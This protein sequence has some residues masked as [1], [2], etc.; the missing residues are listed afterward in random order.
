MKVRE[1]FRTGLTKGDFGVEIEVEGKKL[2]KY[3]DGWRSEKDGSLRGESMEYVLDQPQSSKGLNAALGRLHKSFEEGGAR[4]DESYRA[5]VHV[6]LN[7]QELTGVQLATFITTYYLTEKAL[8]H[9]C[10]KTRWGN[11]FCLRTADAP[12][13]ARSTVEIFR[14]RAPEKFNN[15][16]YRYSAMNLTALPKY[17]S[18]EFRAMESTFNFDKIFMFAE[19]HRKVRDWAVK[20]T[21]PVAVVERAQGESPRNL[22]AEIFG[23]ADA[24]E[25]EYGEFFEDFDEGLEFAEDLAY[26]REWGKRSADI[27]CQKQNLW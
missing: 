9:T 11:H 27:F 26:S 2:P 3:V 13:A 17:G 20:Q 15:D 4:F 24:A 5:G 21:G 18:I 19:R 23:K 6:H 12:F 14:D 22:F 7:V 8:V 10:N 1:I 25:L 16:D